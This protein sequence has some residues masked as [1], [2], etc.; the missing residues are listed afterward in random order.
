MGNFKKS[1][2]DKIDKAGAREREPSQLEKKL[3]I[4]Q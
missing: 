1:H 3:R 2:G 4:I